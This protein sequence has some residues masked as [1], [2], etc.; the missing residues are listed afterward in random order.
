MNKPSTLL[1][2]ST[3]AGIIGII[4]LI[5][6]VAM[7]SSHAAAAGDEL[8]VARKQELAVIAPMF[9][10]LEITSSC[11]EKGPVFR[12]INRGKKWP[13]HGVL[14]LYRT[15][16]KSAMTERK[17]RLAPN[18]KVSFV[19]NKEKSRGR[20]IGIWIEPEWYKREFSYDARATC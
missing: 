6:F 15:D 20:P 7:L 10:Q 18:Q 8:S 5:G 1:V 4:G 3:V 12:I 11:T 17:L 13:R 19:I 9:L 2:I 14:H 16:D